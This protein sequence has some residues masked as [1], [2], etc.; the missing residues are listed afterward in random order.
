MV[1]RDNEPFS[2]KVAR[3]EE[4][5]RST[6]E[7]INFQ[8][9]RVAGLVPGCKAH[10]VAT[11]MLLLMQDTMHVLDETYRMLRAADQALANNAA[12]RPLN[13]R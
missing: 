11:S 5:R 2:A 12:S 7:A 10:R 4:W 13:E 1:T 9:G 3:S 6:Q 8:R